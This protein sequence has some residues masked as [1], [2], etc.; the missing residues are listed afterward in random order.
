M[1]PGPG[2]ALARDRSTLHPKA[3]ELIQTSWIGVHAQEAMSMPRGL[4]QTGKASCPGNEIKHPLPGQFPL[5]YPPAMW[6]EHSADAPAGIHRHLMPPHQWLLRF[7]QEI[8]QW[9]SSEQKVKEII[10][11]Q[12]GYTKDMLEDTLDLEADLGIDTVKQ[13]EIFAKAAGHFGFPSTRGSQITG[14]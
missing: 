2:G 10:A 1:V 11:E 4:Y 9:R 14:S 6:P 5:G 3:K 13:V 8:L 7:L 12:T